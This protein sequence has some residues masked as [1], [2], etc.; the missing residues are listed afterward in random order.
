MITTL[1]RAVILYLTVILA[2]RLMGKR[3]IGEMQPTELVVTILLSEVAAIP[4]QD[5]DIPLINSVAS[6]LLLVSLAIFTSVLTL[7]NTRCRELFEGHPAILVRNGKPDF[8]KMKALRITVQDLLSALRQK[9]VFE[10]SQVKYAI[11][12]T[13]GT[14]SVMLKEEYLPLCQGQVPVKPE[15]SELEHLIV[16]DGKIL[17]PALSSTGLTEHDVLRQLQQNCVPLEKVM[18]LTC[19]ESGYKSLIVKEEDE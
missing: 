8:K 4:L 17:K 16:C 9:D 3:Q 5:N 1:C 18:L 7:H 15:K 14:V 12:E 6:V 13:N 11:V 2:V 10:L 19:G